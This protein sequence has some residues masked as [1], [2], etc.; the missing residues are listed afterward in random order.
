[1]PH[2]R[3][4]RKS[5]R[6]REV[7][8]E[9]R[10]EDKPAGWRPPSGRQ[11]QHPRPKQR[12]SGQKPLVPERHETHAASRYGM[13]WINLV[14]S[15]GRRAL[16]ERTR[17][18]HSSGTSR[19]RWTR[20]GRK[21]EGRPIDRDVWR[22]IGGVESSAS[23]TVERPGAQGTVS[24]VTPARMSSSLCGSVARYPDDEPHENRDSASASRCSEAATTV[25][26]PVMRRR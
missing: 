18:S 3:Q 19:F 9:R 16:S 5:A 4:I 7:R 15:C 13:S 11:A 14:S 1:M 17:P 23:R 22:C 20:N 10:L 26:S 12:G 6:R 2:L 8:A 25:P 24:P 21:R